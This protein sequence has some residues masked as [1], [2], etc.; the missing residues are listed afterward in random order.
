MIN[1]LLEA[2]GLIFGSFVVAIAMSVAGWRIFVR[3][4]HP[5]W[6]APVL[7]AAFVIV[8]ATRIIRSEFLSMVTIL[9]LIAA[10]FLW[11]EGRAW[12]SRNRGDKY[13]GLL[14]SKPY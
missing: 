6:S 7:A 3:A 11:V 8:L 12:R 5:E 2:L 1:A 9:I 14:P 10:P 13:R 4:R